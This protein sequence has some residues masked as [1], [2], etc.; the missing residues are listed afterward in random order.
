MAVAAFGTSTSPDLAE[1]TNVSGPG[2]SKDSID[3]S[4]H[5]GDQFRQFVEGLMDGG[6]VTIEGQMNSTAITVFLAEYV[7][8]SS[9]AWTITYPT[10]MAEGWSFDGWLEGFDSGN[11]VDGK[12]SFTATIKVTGKPTLS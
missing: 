12:C 1:I 3:V 9:T 10:G 4:H 7:K 6:S 8:T 11:P 2:I 5:G